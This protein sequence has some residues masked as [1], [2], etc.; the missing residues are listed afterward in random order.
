MNRWSKRPPR[1]PSAPALRGAPAGVLGTRK[2][3]AFRTSGLGGSTGPG[4]GRLV[5]TSTGAPGP[6]IARCA[7]TRRPRRGQTG[8]LNRPRWVEPQ[9]NARART[10]DG[11]HRKRI[12][13]VQ[14]LVGR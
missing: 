13:R 14:T 7:G 8:E 3:P 1:R 5:E 12:Q 10:V 11:E 2:N 6:I 9:L 4:V